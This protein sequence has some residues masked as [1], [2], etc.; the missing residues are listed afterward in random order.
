MINQFQCDER[1]IQAMRKR[2]DYRSVDE[3]YRVIADDGISVVIPDPSIAPIIDRVRATAVITNEHLR[4]L[5][6]FM[7]NLREKDEPLKN[8]QPI[9][10][11]SELRIFLGKYEESVGLSLLAAD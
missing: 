3:A 9:L 7:V 6:R 5:Q 1:G 8:S 2:L 4:R 10:P 11:D